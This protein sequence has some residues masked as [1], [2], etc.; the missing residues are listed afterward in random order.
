MHDSTNLNKARLSRQETG[1][2]LLEM[3]V[4]IALLGI[5][6]GT[7]LL[8]YEGV[9]EQGREE[10]TRF[11]MAEIRKALLQFRRDSGSHDFPGQGIYDCT[12]DATQIA[13][14][15]SPANF[16]MLFDDPIGV[17]WNDDTKRGWHGPY[18]RNQFTVVNYEAVTGL[19]GVVDPYNN[20]YLMLGLGVEDEDD[21]PRLVSMGANGEYD[22][23]DDGEDDGEDDYNPCLAKDDDVVVCLL[24]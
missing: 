21:E 7:V 24:R 1:F 2:T 16:W 4:V 22:S 13:W 19:Q 10:M 12:G 15:Q 6:S 18:L 5:I 23:E 17:D 14:C 11:E 9:Q 8:G 3:V 20:P